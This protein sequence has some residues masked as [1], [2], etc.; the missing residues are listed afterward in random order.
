MLRLE[1]NLK[2]GGK[3]EINFDR[4]VQRIAH[5]HQRIKKNALYKNQKI[6]LKRWMLQLVGH[7]EP[8]FG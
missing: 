2:N 4:V 1:Q 7:L 8:I 5:L 3:D 6:E